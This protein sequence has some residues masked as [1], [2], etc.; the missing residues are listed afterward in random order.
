MNNNNTTTTLCAPSDCRYSPNNGQKLLDLVN[1]LDLTSG[2]IASH[3]YVLLAR[4][5]HDLSIDQ[6]YVIKQKSKSLYTTAI[7]KQDHNVED[8]KDDTK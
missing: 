8:I 6:L 5:G 4:F 2:E 7:F 3:I 1:S